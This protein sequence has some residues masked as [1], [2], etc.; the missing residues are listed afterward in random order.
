VG[1]LRDERSELANIADD[2][3]S[4]QKERMGIFGDAEGD[5]GE[6]VEVDPNIRRILRGHHLLYA[7]RRDEVIEKRWRNQSGSIWVK[8]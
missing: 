5:C 8:L 4:V 2:L 1:R 3:F 6:G 7:L